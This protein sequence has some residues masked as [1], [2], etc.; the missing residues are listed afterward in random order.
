MQGLWPVECSKSTYPGLDKFLCLACSPEQPKVTNNVDGRK[1]V[2]I[3]ESLLRDFYG[4]EDMKSPTE[5][6][7]ECGAWNS[8]DTILKPN[9]NDKATTTFYTV[10]SS[11]NSRLIFPKVEFKDAEAFYDGFSQAQIPFFGDFKI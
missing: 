1:F 6:F 2:R 10:G 3:C 11:E 7:E 4:N 8:P 5:A 9:T